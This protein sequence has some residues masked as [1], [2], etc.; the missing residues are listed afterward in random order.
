M[1]GRILKYTHLMF[2]VSIPFGRHLCVSNKHTWAA[3]SIGTEAL[4]AQISRK[5]NTLQEFSLFSNAT[6]KLVPLTMNLI[7]FIELTISS[8]NLI[9]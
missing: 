7:L 3:F 5:N 1:S 6:A 2:K 8:I 9:V 4:G